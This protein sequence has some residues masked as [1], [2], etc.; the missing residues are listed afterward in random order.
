METLKNTLFSM[1]FSSFEKTFKTN[2]L[3][4]LLFHVV[5]LFFGPKTFKNSSVFGIFVRFGWAPGEGPRLVFKHLW[6]G[7]FSVCSWF[8]LPGRGAKPIQNMVFYALL[9]H[10]RGGQEVF[11]FMLF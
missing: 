7:I 2:G 3:Q 5:A 10:F 6:L 4:T 1:V 9:G 11:I 8:L